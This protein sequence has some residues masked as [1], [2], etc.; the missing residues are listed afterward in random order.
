MS[1]SDSSLT[2]TVAERIIEATE[3]RGMTV[4][5]LKRRAENATPPICSDSTLANYLNESRPWPLNVL[6]RLSVE[7]LGVRLAFIVDGT[8]PMEPETQP[9]LPDSLEELGF[10]TFEPAVQRRIVR[11]ADSLVKAHYRSKSSSDD[12]GPSTTLEQLGAPYRTIAA[13]LRLPWA[14]PLF[15]AANKP[16]PNS[17][18]DQ[19]LCHRLLDTIEGLQAYQGP[20]H[21]DLARDFQNLV[22]TEGSEEIVD[23]DSPEA[24]ARLERERRKPW[25]QQDEEKEELARAERMVRIKEVGAA[26]VHV[27]ELMEGILVHY[28]E[29]ENKYVVNVRIVGDSTAWEWDTK[30]EATA[31][32]QQ[33]GKQLIAAVSKVGKAT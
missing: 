16:D 13:F 14:L 23:P 24:L 4:A 18:T 17:R 20:L 12:D 5:E 32:A 33:Y 6:T 1:G 8:E 19:D 22:L 29:R 10:E 7:I 11:L 30:H 3:F 25:R 9:V 2:M 28:S 15:L 21:S 27:N 26:R 31:W